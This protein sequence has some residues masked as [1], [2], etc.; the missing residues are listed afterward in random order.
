[1][2]SGRTIPLLAYI[3]AMGW[4][5]A[6]MVLVILQAQGV[7]SGSVSRLFTVAL[8]ILGISGPFTAIA[9][10]LWRRAGGEPDLPVGG[11]CPRCRH[12]L[13]EQLAEGRATLAGRRSRY[14]QCPDCGGMVRVLK[15]ELR[16]MQVHP[17]SSPKAK[18]RR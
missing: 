1:M 3:A 18:L 4:L 16:E 11:R 6:L 14:I 15:A 10:L 13:S 8:L 17:S 7:L 12:D 2:P 5:L 9:V